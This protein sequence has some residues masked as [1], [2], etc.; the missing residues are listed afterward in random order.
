ML[1][2]LTATR[3]LIKILGLFGRMMKFVR[4]Q[5]S[6]VANAISGKP[7]A[8]SSFGN[9]TIDIDD[10]A[11]ARKMLENEGKP[12]R[13]EA[14]EL[15]EN[16]FAKWNGSNRAFAYASG[17]G[18]LSSCIQAL[19]I[20]AGDE[21][22]VPGYTCVVVPN[23]FSFAGVNVKYCDIELDTY[24]IDKDSL[25]GSITNK[26]KVIL[27]HHLYGL[28]CRDYED[29]V[30]IAKERGIAV[31]EDCAQSTGAEFKGVKV[32]NLGDM[33][34]YS[35][36]N[37]KV[38]ST[39]QGGVAIT[40][41]EDLAEKMRLN[42][43]EMRV[44]EL[45]IT[46]TLLKAVAKSYYSL[47]HPNRF[48]MGKAA[49][50]IYGRGYPISTT[51]EEESGIRPSGYGRKMAPQIAELAINQLKKIDRYNQ[52]R[53]VTAKIWDDWIADKRY[54]PPLVAKN[55]TPIYLRYPLLVEEGKKRDLSWAIDEFGFKP[56]VWFVSNLHP[57][58]GKV[59]GCPNA[60]TAVRSC[61]NLPGVIL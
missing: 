3:A 18:A 47:K 31:I 30:A 25:I 26:T 20:L 60:D 1:L 10:V 17:R 42:N 13:C 52:K 11:L 14:A 19:E 40:N 24:G 54:K 39:I 45:E 51:K 38:F 59:H 4:N 49:K 48:W 6:D 21:A 61:I 50:I 29:I 34:F 41:R 33:A 55:S 57:A 7:R 5:I 27:L 12:I 44:S 36:E 22:I 46:N 56:G 8:V 43:K 16:E 23:A 58:P 9:A 2:V 28:V 15:F 53:R 37:S 32:G 35:S